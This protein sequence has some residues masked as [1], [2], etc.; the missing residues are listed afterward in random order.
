[1]KRAR[2]IARRSVRPPRGASITF[3]PPPPVKPVTAVEP[4]VQLTTPRLIR[5]GVVYV[6]PSHVS[7]ITEEYQVASKA[8]DTP[9]AARARDILVGTRTIQILDTPDNMM[10]LLGW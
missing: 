4:M 5:S 9:I 6:R 8:T 2:P 10:K 1:M 7:I 3:T